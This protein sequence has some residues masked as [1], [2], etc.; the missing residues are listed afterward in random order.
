MVRWP[1]LGRL[2]GLVLAAVL[3]LPA[4]PAPLVA[5][6]VL[7]AIVAPVPRQPCRRHPRPG[8]DVGRGCDL[9]QGGDSRAHPGSARRC[10]RG[11]P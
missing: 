6:A 1:V 5:T 11:P 3:V 9:V 2:T 8:L 4:A 10:W 7:P